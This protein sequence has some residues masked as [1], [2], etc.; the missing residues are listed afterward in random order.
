MAIV[1]TYEP[2]LKALSALLNNL[3]GQVDIVMLID[4]GSINAASLNC[5]GTLPESRRVTV[6]LLDKNIGLAEAQNIGIEFANRREATHII[7]FD[8]DS[9]PSRDMVLQLLSAEHFLLN[10]KKNVAAVGPCYIDE[11]QE[12]PPPF[13]SIVGLQLLRHS[14]ENREDPVEVDYLIA[15]G[16]L[17]RTEVLRKTGLMRGDFFIDYIDIE[18]GLRAK[19]L[20]FR[21]FGVCSA[22]MN[23]S[24]GDA[25]IKWMGKNIPLHSPIRHYF[26]FRNAVRLYCEKG[27]P[28]NWKIVD[29]YK[30]F[31]KFFFYSIYATPRLNHLSN[32]LAGIRDGILGRSGGK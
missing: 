7:L 15:S 14:C 1:V 3:D 18:W 9:L 24:L 13:I 31:L 25:P 6:Q 23:H 11:R 4:N 2:D 32:M 29:G 27:I 12:N 5:F 19:R 10:Q 26:H 28:L 17:I 8:Q 21:S 20:G 30:L 16:S 22:K